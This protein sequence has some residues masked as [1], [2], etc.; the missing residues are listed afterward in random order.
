[1]AV[2]FAR[3]VFALPARARTVV[4][5]AVLAAAAASFV[6]AQFT[7]GPA[8]DRVARALVADGWRPGDDVAVFGNRSEFRSPLEWYL[9][10]RPVLSTT[11]ASRID[12]P[13]FVV[14]GRSVDRLDA[15]RWRLEWRLLRRASI[16]SSAQTKTRS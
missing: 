13:V 8:Y 10:G 11:V 9:P 1:V 14:R 4:P 12:E 15:R 3:A 5:A 16:F 6:W 2:A 7:P